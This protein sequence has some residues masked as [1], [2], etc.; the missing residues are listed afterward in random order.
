MIW[1]DVMLV[2]EFQYWRM[3]LFLLGIYYILHTFSISWMR[4]DRFNIKANVLLRITSQRFRSCHFTCEHFTSSSFLSSRFKGPLSVVYFSAVFVL[5]VRVLLVRV[6]PVQSSPNI[7]LIRWRRVTPSVLSHFR[8]RR[9]S[10]L[11]VFLRAVWKHLN[12]VA[13][14]F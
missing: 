4:N 3:F 13:L 10:L 12:G 6:C 1:P 5:K 11:V 2:R 14:F 9:A 8:K 7:L